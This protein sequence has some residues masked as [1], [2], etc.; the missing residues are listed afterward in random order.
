MKNRWLRPGAVITLTLLVTLAAVALYAWRMNS[1]AVMKVPG[2]IEEY[3]FWDARKLNDFRLTTAGNKSFGPEQLKG[4]WSFIFFGYT[5]CPDVCPVTLMELGTVFKILEQNPDIF[6]QMQGI[7]VSVDPGRDTAELL[8]EYVSYFH[9]DFIGLTGEKEQIDHFSR[10]I[11]ALYSIRA[12]ESEEEYEVTHNSTIFLVD[13]QGRLYGR[14]A[15]PQIAQEIAGA[16]I[17]IH[18][19]YGQQ[20]EKRWPLF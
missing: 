2:E 5:H 13:P 15:P 9:P 20:S 17:R 12:G 4:K 14:F 19:F 3:L 6:P 1:D 11:G 16:F 18:A 8:G 7:F 10:Q